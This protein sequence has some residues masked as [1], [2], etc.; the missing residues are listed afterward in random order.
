MKIL[1][2][3]NVHGDFNKLKQIVE[4][5]QAK[6]KIFDFILCCGKVLSTEKIYVPKERMPSDTYFV[7]SSELSQ[8]LMN[9]N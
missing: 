5:L 7:D 2:T 4:N 8:V 6:G 3:G 9:S 1:I